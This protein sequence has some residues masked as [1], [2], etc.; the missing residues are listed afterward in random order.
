MTWVVAIFEAF[1]FGTF[2][3]PAF[4]ILGTDVKR[5]SLTSWH[6]GRFLKPRSS[7][8]KIVYV[9]KDVGKDVKDVDTSEYGLLSASYT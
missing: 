8:R 7:K 9:V 6:I 4:A 1:V 5:W 3:T 2:G